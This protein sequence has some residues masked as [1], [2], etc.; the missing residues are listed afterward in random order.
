MRRLALVVVVA[1]VAVGGTG[2]ERETKQHEI[3]RLAQALKDPDELVRARATNVLLTRGEESVPALVGLLSD[4]DPAG[5]RVA[6]TTLWG[7]GTKARAAVPNLAAALSDQ[8]TVVRTNAAMALAAM[9][10]VS[11]DAVPALIR[12]L[13][14]PD[15]NVRLWAVK[16]LGEIGP[17][18]SDALP[19]LDYMSKNDYLGAPVLEAILKIR[20]GVEPTPD[21]REKRQRMK[22]RGWH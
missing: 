8:D 10:P 11:K 9:G 3:A 12:T 6:A 20:A 21:P 13:S 22:P 18:A 1:A 17:P 7:L 5:R 16:A 19:K 15:R 4:S 14:D 2:C